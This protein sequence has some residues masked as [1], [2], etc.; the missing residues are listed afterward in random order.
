[1]SF[2]GCKILFQKTS[3]FGCPGQ[4]KTP[5]ST[6]TGTAFGLYC[7]L[8]TTFFAD[9]S[10][11]LFKHDF[12]TFKNKSVSKGAGCEISRKIAASQVHFLCR[13]LPVLTLSWVQFL[14]WSIEFFGGRKNK[15][16]IW[17]YLGSVYTCKTWPCLAECLHFGFLS[18]ACWN[19]TFLVYSRQIVRSQNHEQCRVHCLVC[20]YCCASKSLVGMEGL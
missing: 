7:F 15:I 13:C 18:S 4:W 1:M 19:S 9:K 5:I 17:R 6:A 10:T 14:D 3:F 2:P 16:M 12:K 20:V 8:P 11:P